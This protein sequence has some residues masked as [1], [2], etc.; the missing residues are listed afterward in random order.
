[1]ALIGIMGG[2]FNPIHFGHIAIAQAAYQQFCLDEIRFMPNHLPAYKPADKSVT[3]EDRFVM[4]ALGIEDYSYFTASDFELKRE[5]TTYT[6]ETMALLR[7][8]YPEDKFYF[9]MGADSLYNFTKWVHPELIVRNAN[10]LAAPRNQKKQPEMQEQINKLNQHFG[11]KRF[12]LIDCPEI[13]CSSTD[14]RQR[15]RQMMAEDRRIS[16]E[17]FSEELGVPSAVLQYIQ[18]NQLY[19]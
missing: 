11:R 17:N 9:I 8:T 12:F 4:T 14:I 13:T 6:Y 5:G 15:I 3:G 18:R 1:M 10:I 7:Q 16:L 2:T 19:F